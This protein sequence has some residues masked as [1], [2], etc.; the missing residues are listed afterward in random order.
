MIVIAYKKKW[1]R[2]LF[3]GQ[4]RISG[5]NYFR[6]TVYHRGG[7]R[8]KVFKF[9]DYKRYVWNVNGI[10]V[11]REYDAKKRLMINVCI[12]TNGLLSYNLP[13]EGVFIGSVIACGSFFIKLNY[14]WTSYLCII[15]NGLVNNV[16]LLSGF[17]GKYCR[18]MGS[19]A[20]IINFLPGN[21][22]LLKLIKTALIIK[23]KGL[24]VA[25]IGKIVKQMSVN[26]YSFNKSVFNL[27]QG[28][29]PHTRGYAM[30]PIDHPHGGRTKAGLQVS[31]WGKLTKGGK[32]VK[33]K[34]Y[35]VFWEKKSK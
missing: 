3:F 27:R 35:Y 5:K 4:R 10:V 19:F 6:V 26:R 13:V 12:Y 2:Y 9:I 31:A 21:F 28:W 33:K 7:A 15:S 11:G 8:K 30:N 24:C 20:K 25:T 34:S 22:V 23:I 32:T 17:G 16:E 1:F 18:S 29:R 14:G